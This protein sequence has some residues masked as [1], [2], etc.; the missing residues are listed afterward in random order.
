[1]N[2]MMHL[3]IK[4]Y[5]SGFCKIVLSI[6]LT[7]G[8]MTV[9]SDAQTTADNDSI[10]K[11]LS[12]V[13]IKA[14]REIH[15]DESDVIFL[16]EKNR[17]FGTNALDA[18]SSLRQ[19]SPVING[20]SLTT[21][22]Q[23]AVTIMINGRPATPQDL[24]GYTGKEIKQVTYYPVAPPRYSD[25]TDGPL[26]DVTIKVNRDY[27]SAFL[28]ASHSV[29]AGFGTDQAVVRWADSLNMLRADYF[30]DYRNLSF[31][32]KDSYI[33]PATPMLNRD[34]STK[35]KYRGHYQYGKMSWQNTAK[36]NFLHLS[37]MFTHT[38]GNREYSNRT[39][40]D[41]L[42]GDGTE[43]EGYSRFLE[44]NSDIGSINF[45][46]RR[47]TG[48]GRLDFQANGS[49][50]KTSSEN[51]IE[52]ASK[53]EYGTDLTNHTYMAYGKLM[54]H[55]PVN[56]VNL[57]FSGSY[58]YQ[59]IDHD[60]KLP[61]LYKYDTDRN[62]LN[63]SAAVSG[64]FT[65]DDKRLNYTLG[66]AMNYQGTRGGSQGVDLTHCRFTPYLT[67]SSPLS[68]RIF[69]RLR[70]YI[71]SGMPGVGELS[72]V[73]TYQENNL[74]WRGDPSLKGWTMYGV[75]LQPEWVA[76]PGKLSF[77][78]DFSFQ[79][80]TD[81]IKECVY[82]GSP[83]EV[84]YVN[85]PYLRNTEAVLFMSIT[86]VRLLT[87]KPYLQWSY[88]DFPTPGRKVEKG[89]FRYG[90]SVSL[91]TQRIQSVVAVNCPYKTFNGDVMEYGDWQLSC[92]VLAELPANLS[93]S[94]EWRRSYQNDRT[95]IHAP[96]ILDYVSK[97]RY[98]RLANQITVGLTW[99]FS[100]GIFKKRQQLQVE[101]AESDSGISD[102]NKAKM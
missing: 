16:S 14:K 41:P 87:L 35:G 63:L 61:D 79:Y 50:G 18:V 30:I 25:V 53:P 80:T 101:D 48:K 93:L 92:S 60:R 43:E 17:R 96:G 37:A 47:K 70:G 40:G 21:A 15:T 6:F 46:Y 27:I 73:L 31:D 36:N 100:H 24:R 72:D 84:R 11:T 4:P 102:F 64:K 51:Y 5:W 69:L 52:S 12:E 82:S 68:D 81:P 10:A 23:K 55:I 62:T 85:L 33:Y 1:M 56:G 76:F 7:L 3:I 98:P 45:F 75:T 94:L 74:A 38:P 54:Y 91:N 77:N 65:R 58:R 97:S 57:F 9:N 95:E 86:P 59:H 71:K 83:V 88:N 29:N 99:S 42:S 66:L 67:L 28:S 13:V 49:V 32:N 90:G 2:R 39:I 34:Y 89:Y 44:S 78:G 26:I 22:D 19:F 8:C 20:M